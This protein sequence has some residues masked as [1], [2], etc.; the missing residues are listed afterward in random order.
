MIYISIIKC[1]FEIHFFLLAAVCAT[2]SFGWS[3]EYIIR[4]VYR[5]Y[6]VGPLPARLV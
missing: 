2:K 4:S 3:E 5:N 1:G 6:E